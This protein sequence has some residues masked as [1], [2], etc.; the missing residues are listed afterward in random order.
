MFDKLPTR[1][2]RRALLSLCG[3]SFLALAFE[4]CVTKKAANAQV[5][6]AYLA[7]QQE[8]R[9]QMQQTQTQGQGPCVTVN[10]EVSNHV[11]PWTQ[12]LTLAKAL[13]AANYQGASDPGQIIIVH[14]G[15]AKRV[16]PRQLLSGVDIP[17][18]PGD[19]VQ[20]MPQAAAPKQ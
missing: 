17:L 12:G 6:K 15:L 11:V 9:M 2:L 10:G 14:N 4:G 13:L 7:G 8:A 16:D 5:R 20:L 3:A 19:I 1:C 18:Q